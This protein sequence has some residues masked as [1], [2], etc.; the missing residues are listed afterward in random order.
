[1]PVG[2]YEDLSLNEAIPSSIDDLIIECVAQSKEQRLSSAR[3]FNTRLGAL[4]QPTKPLSD[5]LA[6][7]RLHELAVVIEEYS[8]SDFI[9]LPPGQRVLVLAKVFD[10]VGSND[11]ALESAAEGFLE[12]L[13][14]RGVLLE[15]EEYREIVRPAV[16]WGFEKHFDGRTGRE[17]IRKSLEEAAFVSR[18]GAFDILTEEVLSYVATVDLASKE[19]WYLHTMREVIQ[20]LMANPTCESAASDLGKVFRKINQAQRSRVRPPRL[21]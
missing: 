6:H 13:L 16:Q 7:G 10:V 8:A 4:S 5:V 1:M 14:V 3:L 17:S 11:H 12:L 21:W 19:E 18:D 15:K 2:N 9:S 20:A